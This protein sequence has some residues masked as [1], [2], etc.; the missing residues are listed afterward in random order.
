MAS[1]FSGA[2]IHWMFACFR[3][4]HRHGDARR[5]TDPELADAVLG[6]RAGGVVA[7]LLSKTATRIRGKLAD[8]DAAG[9]V[10]IGLARVAYRPASLGQQDVDSTA[11]LLFRLRDQFPFPSRVNF[12]FLLNPSTPARPARLPI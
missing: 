2:N 12:R 11:G 7:D 3:F 5:G 8:G 10:D 6:F 1:P 9:G 4:A